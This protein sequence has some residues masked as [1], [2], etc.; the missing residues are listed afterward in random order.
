MHTSMVRVDRELH[1]ISEQ[2]NTSGSLF[3][4]G[5]TIEYIDRH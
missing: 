2:I 4:A 5:F 3:K 1:A